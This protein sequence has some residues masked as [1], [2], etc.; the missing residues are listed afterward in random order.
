[1]HITRQ[2][3]TRLRRRT[4]V[5]RAGYYGVRR[6]NLTTPSPLP[7]MQSCPKCKASLPAGFSGQECPTCG[8][9]FSKYF[10]AQEAKD[11]ARLERETEEARK[12]EELE[13]RMKVPKQTAA[14]PVHSPPKT[15]ACPTCGGLVA[16]GAKTCPHC[17]QAKPAPKK[18]GTAAYVLAG[19]FL[20]L[21]IVGIANS[22]GGSGGP[23]YD[24]FNAQTECEGFVRRSLKAPSSADFAPHRELAISGQGAGPWT[25]VG[26]VDAQNAFGAKIR[27]SYVCEVQF[28]GGTVK[29]LNLSI[30]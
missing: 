14:A 29:L 20:V 16:I 22:P 6:Q 8:V 28:S 7:P 3:T 27:S 12:A 1:M 10:A 23:R 26:W 19:L 18:A 15:A 5:P 13:R 2:L 24:A 9:I 25:V 17:G 11:K 21:F 30:R 4:L